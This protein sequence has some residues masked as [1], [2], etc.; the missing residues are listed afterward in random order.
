MTRGRT[1]SARPLR[2][3]TLSRRGFLSASLAVGASA[4]LVACGYDESAGDGGG[5]AA[6]W[7]YTDER[8][9]KLDGPRPQRIVAQVTA[10]AALWDFGIRPIGIFGPSKL[11]DGSPDPQVGHVDLTKVTSL[12]NVWG[13]FNYDAFLALKPDLLV[14]TMYS[15]DE[16]WYVPA[17]LAADVEKAVPT[18]GV[19]LPGISMPEGIE[20]FRALAKALGADVDSPSVQQARAAFEQADKDFGAAARQLDGKKVMVASATQ[21]LFYVAAPEQF[22][23]SNYMLSKNLD[24][25]VP[26]KLP[27]GGFWEELSW[28]NAM[29]YPADVILLDNRTGYLSS[30]QLADNP[31]WAS[32]PAVEAGQVIEWNPETPFSYSIFAEQLNKLAGEFTRVAAT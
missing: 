25:V 12:G 32:L 31:A 10:A 26:Q 18:V 7:S 30:K 8:G 27:A 14:S 22:P 5:Q 6:T 16:L 29:R 21:D 23:P 9:R 4:A 28:E 24:M 20:K 2:D 3:H 19:R 15:D 1:R 13:E 17:E 11:P